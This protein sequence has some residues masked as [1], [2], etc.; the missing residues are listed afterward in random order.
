LPL[1]ITAL[2]EYEQTTLELNAGDRITLMTDGVVEAQ[3]SSGELFG[4]DRIR[5][6]SA[7]SAEQ[8]AAVA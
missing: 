8:I 2:S 1:G 6:I 5:G 7:Q 3:S 4:F